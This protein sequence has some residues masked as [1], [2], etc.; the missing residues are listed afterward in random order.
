MGTGKGT[1]KS[2][3]TCLSKLPFSKL[4]LVSPRNTPSVPPPPPI[5]E[6]HSHPKH[7]KLVVLSNY[8]LRNHFKRVHVKRGACHARSK[9]RSRS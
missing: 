5:I 2:M 8:E 3:R 6:H 1:G 9:L 4:P 7:P